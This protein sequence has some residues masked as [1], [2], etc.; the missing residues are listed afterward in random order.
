MEI[1]H[2]LLVHGT[3]C[4]V[5]GIHAPPKP[6]NPNMTPERTFAIDHLDNTLVI[7]MAG[8]LFHIYDI[9]KMDAPAHQR[10]SSLKYMTR[11]LAFM[12]GG[13]GYTTASVERR[14]TVE[15]FDPSPASQEKKC[16]FKCHRQTIDDVE[17]AWPVNSLAFHP[18]YNTFAS[19]GSD[20]TVPIWNHK[21]K[22][23]LRQY[24]KLS[25]PVRASRRLRFVIHQMK[26]RK[27]R[28]LR[29]LHPGSALGRLE[30]K[31]RYV[32]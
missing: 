5:S 29:R 10:E 27:A 26:Q 30:M 7:A 13:Q 28:G 2:P 15:Y 8:C 3:A 24:P 6:K 9:R 14:I 18:V 4:C 21:V 31:Q 23:R 12:H 25:G 11:S 17:H 32:F 16:T 20:G 19:D 1:S 22:K